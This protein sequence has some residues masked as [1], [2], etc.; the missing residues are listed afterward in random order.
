MD[1]RHHGHAASWLISGFSLPVLD[2]TRKNL[3]FGAKISA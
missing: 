1:F 3:E 2:P